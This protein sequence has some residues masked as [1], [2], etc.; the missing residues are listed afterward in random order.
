MASNS[1]VTA[2]VINSLPKNPYS[3]G[4]LGGD[5]ASLTFI[6]FFWLFITLVF[7]AAAHS[8]STNEEPIT[9]KEPWLMVGALGVYSLIQATATWYEASQVGYCG[10]I[11]IFGQSEGSNG[12]RCF[13]MILSGLNKFFSFALLV[14]TAGATLYAPT[15]AGA[16]LIQTKSNS[17]EE[18][19]VPI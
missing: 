15:I 4:T 19:P 16:P 6:G 2:S 8:A 17:R 14:F 1:W 3:S 18:T 12:G 11:V 9:R 7:A 13:G 10:A 5:A